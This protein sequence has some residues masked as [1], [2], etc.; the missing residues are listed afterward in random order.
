M[1]NN[2]SKE[3][4]HL[5]S[6]D[7][8]IENSTDSSSIYRGNNKST[9][10]N[11]TPENIDQIIQSGIEI[12]KNIQ[13]NLSQNNSKT[14]N[15]TNTATKTTTTNTTTNN[16]ANS[17]SSNDSN[18]SISQLS[19]LLQ[20]INNIK[21]QIAKLNLDPTQRVYFDNC[22][23]PLLTTL[24]NL[25]SSSDSLATTVNILTT[26]SVVHPKSSQLKD[27]INLIYHMNEQCEDIYKVLKK[28]IDILI[29]TC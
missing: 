16:D 23:N 29:N 21:E 6:Q 22:V 24:Y 11:L 2:N 4:K 25:S 9:G 13:F 5:P 10:A 20:D 3:S 28:R 15:A 14:I 26:S 18:T 27:T 19:T 12:T 17:S 1:S 7:E 8:N